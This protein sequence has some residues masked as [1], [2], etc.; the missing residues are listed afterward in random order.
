[1]TDVEHHYTTVDGHR[2]HYL[3]AGT[4]GPPVVLLHGG[5]I[6][7][8]HLS[9]GAVI[10]PLAERFQVYALDLLGYGR[11]D[12]PDVQYT[13]KRH[14]DVLEGFLDGVDLDETSLVGIS[15]GGGIALGFA[16][17]APKRVSRLCLI[18]SY[19]LGSEL[20]N[21]RLSYVLSQ[22]PQFNTLSIG[23]LKRSRS[24]ARASLGSIVYDLDTVSEAVVS[25]FYDQLQRPGVAT[26][27]RSWRK[28]EVTRPGY[29]TVFTDRL[30]DVETETLLLHGAADE[31]FPPAWSERAAVRMPN[32]ECTLVEECAHWLPQEKPDLC[33]KLLTNFLT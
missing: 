5:I 9:W 24:L 17:R 6:D 19:G 26:A 25:D 16:L 23:L 15:L 22:I 33:V 12:I 28:H 31:V 18:D 14:I 27:F 1:M 4:S 30:G 29:R 7:A 21:G 10:E 13:T 2:L 11:S 20:P 8:A 3:K 32:A